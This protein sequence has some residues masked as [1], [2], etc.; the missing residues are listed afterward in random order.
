MKPWM[1]AAI[2]LESVQ[3]QSLCKAFIADVRVV[4]SHPQPCVEHRRYI[5]M[6]D[7]EICCAPR[8]TIAEREILLQDHAAP[9]THGDDFEV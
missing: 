9:L 4:A 7:A 3:A 8:E 1:I 6:T 5:R 2:L